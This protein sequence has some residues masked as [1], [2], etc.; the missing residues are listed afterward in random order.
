[1]SQHKPSQLPEQDWAGPGSNDF[2]ASQLPTQIKKL[3]AAHR[4]FT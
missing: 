1:M 3:K 2:S 4:L